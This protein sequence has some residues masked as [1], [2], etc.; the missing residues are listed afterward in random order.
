MA[1]VVRPSVDQLRVLI[2]EVGAL[3]IA[4]LLIWTAA[5]LSSAR[6]EVPDWLISAI[7]SVLGYFFGVEV[8]RSLPGHVAK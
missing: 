4:V 6:Q 2:H 7:F 5:N 1:A 8:G 3:A